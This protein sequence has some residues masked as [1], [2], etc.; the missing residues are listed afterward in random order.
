MDEL[1]ELNIRQ[2]CREKL[3]IW[4]G[5]RSNYYH[6]LVE[7][8]MNGNDEMVSHFSAERSFQL[9]VILYEGKKTISVRDY[10]RGINLLEEHGS[11]PVY[12]ILFE[13]LFAGTNFDNAKNGKETTGTNG[14]GLTVL[15]YTSKYF[16]V[17]CYLP[18]KTTQSICY[19]NGGNRT[20]I[21]FET[22]SLFN[23][24]GTKVTFELDPEMYTQVEYN[25]EIIKALC[26]RLAGINN[27]L[28]VT[29]TEHFSDSYKTYNYKYDSLNDYMK[30]N[31]LQSMGDQ[32][33]F[34][35]RSVTENLEK[36]RMQLVWSIGTEPFQETY[37]N[38]TYLKDGGTIYDG[39]I[40][41]FRKILDK[42]TDSKTKITTADIELGLNFVCGLWTN[43]VE[44]ANQTKFSTKKD[45]YKK[46]VVRYVTDNL[47]AFRLENEKQFNEII[48]HF[49]EINSFN[50]KASDDIKALKQKIQKKS[51]GSGLR[52]EGLRDADMNNSRM[53]ERILIIDEGLSAN[54]TIMEAFDNRYMGCIGLR[55]RFINSYKTNITNV[56][57]NEPALA[58]MAALG[59]GIE[60]PEKE[61]KRLKDVVKFNKDDLRYGS[62]AIICDSDSFGKAITLSLLCY[63]H[64]FYPTL[65]EEGRIYVVGSPRFVL[66][67]KKGNT[68][69]AYNDFEKQQQMLQLGKDLDHV[70]IVKGLGELNKDEFWDYVLSPEARKKTFTQV[71]FSGNEEEIEALFE[72]TMGD[73]I[74]NRK[75]FITEH[76][77]QNFAN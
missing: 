77:V 62:V 1:R 69:Y 2:Q 48:K 64:K 44:F 35:E 37:L 65:C 59:C 45:S 66:Y 22:N 20:E 50:K 19:E 74:K 67:D 21:S 63:F 47:E 60:L 42:Y 68:H 11:T 4:F 13:T 43:N 57:K 71:N 72:L 10:G 53:E 55:G 14:C 16:E 3:P 54:S 31:C 29:F 27:G 26:N 41:G 30:T 25:P 40:E 28:L 9:D 6:G 73:D 52:V 38:C 7:V 75:E 36:N 8:M 76:V 51:K 58:I 33:C 23:S 32:Y 39:V 24:T 15:N 18:D 34:K 17:E 5:S 61:R 56:F 12:K 46:H 49:I 70:G